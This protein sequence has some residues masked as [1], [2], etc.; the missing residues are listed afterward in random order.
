MGMRV[1]LQVLFSSC[2]HRA[3]H[4]RLVGLVPAAAEGKQWLR[5]AGTIRELRCVRL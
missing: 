5:A 1:E 2:V 3:A 4:L